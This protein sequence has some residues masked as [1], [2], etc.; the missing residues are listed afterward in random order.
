MSDLFTPV[1][2]VKSNFSSDFLKEVHPNNYV[3]VCISKNDYFYY[4]RTKA[5]WSCPFA[6]H[7]GVAA[8]AGRRIKVAERVCTLSVSQMQA[9]EGEKQPLP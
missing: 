7:S 6:E 3:P 5:H 1:I 9:E 8:S 2:T 4:Y